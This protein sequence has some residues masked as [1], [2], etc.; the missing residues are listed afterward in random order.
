[1]KRPGAAALKKALAA[2]LTVQKEADKPLAVLLAGHNGSGKSTFWYERLAPTLK[3]PLI[4]A[5]RMMLSV[6]PERDNESHLP[7]WAAKLRDTDASW[8]AVAQKGVEAFVAQA[9]GQKVP[10]GMETVFS[11]L[12]M[13]RDGRVTESKIDLIRQMQ[14]AGYFVLL[15][16]IGLSNVNLSIG[17]V[18]SRKSVGGN[19]GIAFRAHGKS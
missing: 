17:R 2:V 16:F 4:N 15:V 7:K 5:D 11:H 3:L 18:Q 9:M 19:S 13:D 6:L 10:F 8:M 14:D 12:R 1:V